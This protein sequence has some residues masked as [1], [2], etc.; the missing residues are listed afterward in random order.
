MVTPEARPFKTTGGLA[1]V[2]GALP[3][4]LARM[5]HRVTLVM[6]RYRGVDVAGASS[7]PA[8]VPFGP[9]LYPVTFHVGSPESPDTRRT[10]KATT[11]PAKVA[12]RGS[13]VASAPVKAA[14]RVTATAKSPA[15]GAKSP[16]A[17]SVTPVFIDAPDL[18]DRD[19]LYGD[20]GGEYSDNAFRFAVLSR[21][22]LEYVRFTG[23]RPSVIH[24]HD[25]Q[26]ALVP[27]YLRTVLADDPV[28]GDVPSVLTIHNV[29]FQGLYP[30]D[31]L[32]WIDIAPELYA[33]DG[34]EFY[35]RASLLKAGT[36]FADKV[37]TVSPTYAR[38]LLT[39]GYAF[40][41]GFEGILA[42]RA[43]DFSGIL[44]GIDTETWDPAR[45]RFLPQPFSAASPAAKL[46]AK[47][48]LL[49]AAG[50]PSDKATLARPTIGLLSRLTY[51]KGVDLLTAA[52]DSLMQLD[53]NW[54]LLGD[55]DRQH[56]EFWKALAQ[57]HPE[58]VAT[59][60]GFDE[61]LAHLIHGGCDLFLMPSRYEPCGLN[62][63]YAMRYGT[64]PVVRAT[65]GLEDT[66]HDADETPKGATGFRFRDFT[67]EAL[68]DAVRR[69]LEAFRNARRWK[70]LQRA[71]MKQDHSWDVSAREYV[72]VYRG[73][74]EPR[75]RHGIRKGTDADGRE[76][77]TDHQRRKSRT[78]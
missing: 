63:M 70:T 40:A 24:A 16:P 20:A 22:A 25:W 35:G 65:G 5:G 66:V 76:L 52:S 58:R 75:G 55:G 71:A 59:R 68:V 11:A 30:P 72:K 33:P 49:N 9:N 17:G 54:V 29:A 18:F 2:A 44:N 26:T 43:A 4:A 10:S 38:E 39:P 69:G 31:V 19:G 14:T 7:Q 50:L 37:T 41:F 77:R 61:E 64:L 45:D 67:T 13:R 8:N 42:T 32:R 53:A 60:I 23:D 36:L 47:R 62:Q 28:L 6:P 57:R 12:A 73:M 46:E 56:E 78:R 51:Q 48:A 1:D 34:L 15:G 74:G 21:G 27:L 3:R